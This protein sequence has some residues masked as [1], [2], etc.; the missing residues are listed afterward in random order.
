MDLTFAVDN[1]TTEPEVDWDGYIIGY[2]EKVPII[3][4]CPTKQGITGNRLRW[5]A[6]A[7]LRR[8]LEN[9]PLGSYRSISRSEPFDQMLGSHMLYG[10][11]VTL[12]YSRDVT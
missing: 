6:D 3:I 7:E 1:P 5:Q 11:K 8:V 10:I 4:Q 12:T 9:N 2:T